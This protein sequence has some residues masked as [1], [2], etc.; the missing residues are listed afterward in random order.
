MDSLRMRFSVKEFAVSLERRG[1]LRESEIH[2]VWFATK[3]GRSVLAE[4]TG[5]EPVRP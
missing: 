4:S 3:L 1:W 2:P 5:I